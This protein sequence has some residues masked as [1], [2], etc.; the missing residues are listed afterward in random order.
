MKRMV[1]PKMAAKGPAISPIYGILCAK[2]ATGSPMCAAKSC[3][4]NTPNPI[5]ENET[6]KMKTVKIKVKE[7]RG[8]TVAGLLVS[9]AAWDMDSKP[10]KEMM[11]KEDPYMKLFSDGN[12][13]FH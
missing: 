7:V 6:A 10:T 8:I 12:W 3:Q 1:A 4:V 9:C 2:L 11:A 13:V 5:V